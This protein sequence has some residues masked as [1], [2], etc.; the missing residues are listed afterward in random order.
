MSCCGRRRGC[1]AC[2]AHRRVSGTRPQVPASCRENPSGGGGQ[3]PGRSD[4]S[5]PSRWEIDNAGPHPEQCQRPE[6]QRCPEGG[7]GDARLKESS[8]DKGTQSRRHWWRLEQAMLPSAPCA[9]EDG[10]PLAHTGSALISG[11]QL[12]AL[13]SNLRLFTHQPLG[14][15]DLG[16]HG[17]GRWK[18]GEKQPRGLGQQ[19]GAA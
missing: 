18:S 13:G 19:P 2:W 1:S 12:R 11:A 9:R 7:T 6:I 3:T 14:L 5:A 10:S 8:F 16:L 4:H 15:Q 17:V